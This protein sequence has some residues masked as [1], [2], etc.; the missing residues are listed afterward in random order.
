MQRIVILKGHQV[1]SYRT[2]VFQRG[3]WYT[4]VKLNANI[5][6]L[7]LLVNCGV[8]S[9]SLTYF[10]SGYT[11]HLGDAPGEREKSLVIL[12][13]L[14]HVIMLQFQQTALQQASL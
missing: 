3:H 7:L 6:I 14:C 9:A 4:S 11:S 10:S 1:R 5:P 12:V 2:P 13:L 8:G